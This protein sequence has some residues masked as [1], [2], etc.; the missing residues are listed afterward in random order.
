MP[1]ARRNEQPA[2]ATAPPLAALV[3]ALLALPLLAACVSFS[4][5][6]SGS[7]SPAVGVSAV[8]DMAAPDG[9][10]LGSVSLRQTHYGVLVQADLRG[11]PPGGHGFHVHETGSCSPDFAA[12]GDHYNPGDAGHGYDN[13]DGYHAGDLPNIHVAADG[14]AR[15]DFFTH[16]LTLDAD[17]DLP[18]FD[19]DGAAVIVHEKPDTYGADAGAGGRIACGVIRRN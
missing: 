14:T 12:A 2:H 6:D 15:A 9:T 10:S 5:T 7:S 11:L 1:N 18:L 17:V 3:L 16:A 13:P 8:A 19:E 4:R